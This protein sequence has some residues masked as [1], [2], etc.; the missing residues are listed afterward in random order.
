[1]MLNAK[2]TVGR[3]ARI[4]EELQQ[5]GKVDVSVLSHMCGVS[6]V[7]IRNDLIQL[8]QKGMLIRTRGGALRQESVSTDFA[9]SEKRRRYSREKQLIG[10]KAAEMV[11]DGETIIF[12]SGTTTMEVARNLSGHSDLTILTNAL[13]IAASLSGNQ[14]C[15]VIMLGGLLRV[16]SLSLVGTQA[17]ENLRNY[18]CDKL[19][20]GV[21]GIDSGYGLTTPN[22]EEAHLNRIM[23]D[24]VK[25]VILVTD[26][27][28]FQRRSFAFI[29]PIEKVQTIITDQGIPDKEHK[30]L[31][32]MGIKLVLV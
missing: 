1:M 4:I 7:T 15:R 17:E 14:S 12:D 18:S 26:S 10:K 31:E 5:N 9:L 21:D 25:E 20:L 22:I 3:R 29:S 13:N 23:I 16:K 30:I 32:D 11:K 28:K 6:E 2:T 19:F 8:E 27:S 24:V